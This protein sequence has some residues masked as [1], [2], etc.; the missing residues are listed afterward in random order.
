M[1]LTLNPMFLNGKMDKQAPN[2][3][4]LRILGMYPEPTPVLYNLHLQSIISRADRE[5]IKMQRD[6]WNG[7]ECWVISFRTRTKSLWEMWVV[8][9]RGYSVVRSVVKA[10]QKRVATVASVESDVQK[11]KGTEFWFPRTVTYKRQ[12]NG[13]INLEEVVTIKQAS[14]NQALDENVFKLAGMNIAKGT[15]IA[16]RLPNGQ[17]QA[18]SW[19]GSQVINYIRPSIPV[20]EA[21]SSFFTNLVNYCA[22]GFT[23]LA[24]V[25]GWFYFRTARQANQ[26]TY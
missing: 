18:W 22:A 1:A 15:V 13:E 2:P 10:D 5:E 26:R 11:I 19:D 25:S 20:A 7:E 8:P 17:A 14:F 9:S 12:A 16:G 21:T 4:D 23:L 3:L 6:R 24:L